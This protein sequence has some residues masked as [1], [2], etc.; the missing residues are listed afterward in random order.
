MKL[1][2]DVA[3][4]DLAGSSVVEPLTVGELDANDFLIEL[5]QERI[6]GVG[7]RAHESGKL[8]LEES[9][10]ESLSARHDV[11]MAQSMRAELMAREVS[12]ALTDEGIRHRLLKGASLAHSI[13]RDPN[14]RSFRDVDVLVPGADVDATVALLEKAG[15]K[16]LQPSLRPGFD[17]RF[18]KSVTLRHSDVEI[19]VHRLLAAGPFG[20]WMQPDDLFVLLDHVSLGGVDVPT[21]DRTDH[22]I[23]AC[24]HVALGQASPVLANL[25]DVALLAEDSVDWDRFD[26]TVDRWRGK[27][28]IQRT[29][30][31]LRSRLDTEIPDRLENYRTAS[32]VAD[33]RT[34]IG[35]YLNEDPGGRFAALAQ[36]TLR[37]LPIS[38]RAAYARA[39]GFPEGSDP[40]DRLK[41]IVERVRPTDLF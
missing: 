8:I 13:A 12:V 33:E 9:A 18:G 24:Y 10:A 17:A 40:V 31:V 15:A 34:A 36:A 20:V 21:L 32:V 22:L 6:L 39:V 27:A 1:A 26:Q 30:T 19:D 14:E 41:T 35:P 3:S 38:E 37:T 11:A 7:I 29:V 4:L 25:R 28:V 23:H 5:D 16:R 2:S